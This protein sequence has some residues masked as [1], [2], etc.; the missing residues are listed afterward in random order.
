[1]LKETCFSIHQQD[2]YFKFHIFGVYFHMYFNNSVLRH[3]PFTFFQFFNFHLSQCVL[4][5]K[6]VCMYSALSHY[7][8]NIFIYNYQ[9]AIVWN[10]SIAMVS[11]FNFWNCALQWRSPTKDSGDAST[12]PPFILS[13]PSW[14][15]PI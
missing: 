3:P 11:T 8:N 10:S 4:H 12:S 15:L 6:I 1:M 7:F 14:L 13:S 9:V 5:L 2:Y